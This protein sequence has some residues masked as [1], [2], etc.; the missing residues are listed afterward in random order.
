MNYN[1]KWWAK[2]DDRLVH[3]GDC[4]FWSSELCTCGLI[5]HCY[6]GGDSLSQH[7]W[8]REELQKH[9]L[10]IERLFR[11]R[12]ALYAME[13]IVRIADENII[14]DKVRPSVLRHIRA[15]AHT[16]IADWEPPE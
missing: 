14:V 4:M 8:L 3:D 7:P 5:H 10:A 1:D 13:D 12:S 16:V 15:I 11:E 2:R 9:D 6:T